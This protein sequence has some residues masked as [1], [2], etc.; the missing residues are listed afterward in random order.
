MDHDD[1][2]PGEVAATLCTEIA[3]DINCLGLKGERYGREGSLIHR[4][5]DDYISFLLVCF[6]VSVRLGN[7]CQRIAPIND[8]PDR[9]RLNQPFEGQQIVGRI[10]GR[11]RN[12]PL[13]ASL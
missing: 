5:G 6:D 13:A 8:R 1:R 9:S 2:T 10:T 11:P 7:L 4:Y 3:G 12:D